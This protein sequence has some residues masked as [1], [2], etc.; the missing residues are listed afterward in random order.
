MKVLLLYRNPQDLLI[1]EALALSIKFGGLELIRIDPAGVDAHKVLSI[2]H[3]N[4][5]SV[6][7]LVQI[8]S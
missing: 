7:L 6:H 5:P 3:G 8:C 2:L 4:A 1:G